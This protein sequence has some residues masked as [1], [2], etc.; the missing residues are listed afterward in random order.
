MQCSTKTTNVASKG[1][2]SVLSRFGVSITPSIPHIMAA[3][4][5]ANAPVMIFE[6]VFFFIS[7]YFVL[8]MSF[9]NVFDIPKLL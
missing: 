8:L 9:V 2:P 6:F 4:L 7:C 3:K 1:K 5:T